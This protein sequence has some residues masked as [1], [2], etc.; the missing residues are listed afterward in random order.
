MVCKIWNDDVS[1][2]DIFNLITLGHKYFYLQFYILAV[3]DLK[4][5]S[6]WLGNFAIKSY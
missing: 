6:K 2:T 3:R 4:G 5:V 1:S